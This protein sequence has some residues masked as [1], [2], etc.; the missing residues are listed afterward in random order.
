MNVGAGPFHQGVAL[1]L[2]TGLA[3]NTPF[4][5][6]DPQQRTVLALQSV[7]HIEIV[8]YTPSRLFTVMRAKHAE[9]TEAVL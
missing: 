4:R 5:I 9:I 3:G 6:G 1:V 7:Q 8:A 2:G